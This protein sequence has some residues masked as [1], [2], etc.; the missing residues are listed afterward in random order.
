VLAG[1][2]SALAALGVLLCAAAGLVSVALLYL[3]TRATGA[4][5]DQLEQSEARAKNILDS[6]MD[7]IITVDEH[8]RIVMFNGAAENL[9]GYTQ[10]EV[11]GMALES[12]IPERFRGI[13][14]NHVRQFGETNQTARRMGIQQVVAALHR[15]GTE[16]PIEAAIS[17]TS[18]DAH[19][20]FTVIVRDVSE[21]E[22]ATAALRR[23]AEELHDLAVAAHSAKEQEKSR[24]A[25][26]LHDELGQSL[27]ALK[28]GL[29]LVE[30]RLPPGTQSI[31][32]KMVQMGQLVD[33][34]VA[35]TRRISADLRPLILDDLGLGPALEW[36]TRSFAQRT[37]ID[38][39]LDVRMPDI[40]FREPYATA[41]FRFVQESLNN[42]GKHAHASKVE[43][44]LFNEGQIVVLRVADDGVG[45]DPLA[46]RRADAYGLLGLRERAVLLRG[47]FDIRSQE[48]K[49]TILE[50]QFP[51][52]EVS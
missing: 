40:N 42:V 23:S 8:Q 1:R 52:P 39:H 4:A 50:T 7:G 3:Q 47:S 22:R 28:M 30:S 43:V 35:A 24:I 10:D 14:L 19:K 49:G 32:E 11:L 26:E 16:F 33:S 44:S 15:N 12:L 9:F 5:A 6:A 25:R 37:G 45:F 17:Q 2:W 18:E 46:S 21:R 41:A 38:C 27:T 13:H 36:L 20:F 48:G 51:F 31:A 34:T 29:A